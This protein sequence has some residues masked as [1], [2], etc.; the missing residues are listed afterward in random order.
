MESKLGSIHVQI[1][2]NDGKLQ[3]GKGKDK[4]TF[5]RMTGDGQN[6]AQGFKLYPARGRHAELNAKQFASEGLNST[7]P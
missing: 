7:P 2:G 3:V 5:S 6:Y 1:T 4:K